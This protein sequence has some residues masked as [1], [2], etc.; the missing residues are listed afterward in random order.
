MRKL[1]IVLLSA[2]CLVLLGFT[3]SSFIHVFQNYNLSAPANVGSTNKTGYRLIL[4]TQE[5]DTP[6]W[7]K[8]ESG[9]SKAAAKYG[10]E[11]EVWG[12]YGANQEDFLKNMEIAI[13]SKVDGILVQGLNTDEFNQLATVKAAENGIPIFTIANDVPI[14]D[15]LRRTYIGSDHY[16]AGQMIGTQLAE[17][18]G[19]KGK[20]V[21]MVSD[22]QEDF[23]SKRLNGILSILKFYPNI[24]PITVVAG[25]TREKVVTATNEIMNK[26]PG[27]AAFVSVTANNASAMVQE[28]GKRAQLSRF[29]IY[30]FDDSPEI[31][32]LLK[33]KK[34]SGIIEQSPEMMGEL[35]VQ[36]MVKWLQGESFPLKYDGYYTDIK[37]LK[38]DELP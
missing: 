31:K 13:A 32:T 14:E 6:F 10:A 9:A 36:L 8:V 17:D 1:V 35:G 4:I 28:I 24:E 11:L 22:R 37:L 5:L 3:L 19:Q 38:A 2:I 29:H 33:E 18:L 27:V 26:E 25:D 34:M 7:D 20:V 16:K 23:Q 15:S 21:L 30:S 12:S